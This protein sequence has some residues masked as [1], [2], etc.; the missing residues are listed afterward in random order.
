MT[1]RPARAGARGREHYAAR[2]VRPRPNACLTEV[3]REQGAPTPTSTTCWASSITSRGAWP[4][5]RTMFNEALRINPAYTEAALNLVVTC[6]DLGKYREAKEVYERAMAASKRA[7]RE[8]DPFA[9]GQ[10]RQHARRHRRRL[11]RRRR[12]SR[13]PCAS[14]S[15][16]WRCARRSSTSA[17]SWATTLR[18]MGDMTGR[19]PRVRARAAPRA[20]ASW[21]ARL[22][23]GLGYYAA[24]PARG[25]RRRM[26]AP[27]WR[28]SPATSRAA[29]MYLAHA[30]TRRG[31]AGRA[32]VAEIGRDGG[33]RADLRRRRPTR[34]SSRRSPRTRRRA[35]ASTRSCG[36]RSA[37]SRRSTPSRCWRGALARRCARRRLRGHEGPARDDAPVAERARASTPS[38]RWRCAADGVARARRRRRHG[39][40]LRTGHLRGNRFEVV[41]DRRRDDDEARRC[42]ARLATLGARR[43]C[44]TATASSASAPPATTPPRGL[45]LLRGERRERD[46]RQAQAA[47]VGAAVGGVQP[48]RSSCGPTRRRR[49]AAC[50]AGDVLQKTASGGL[51]V[52]TDAAVDQA[53]VDA[54]ELVTDRAPARRP[55]D[56]AAARHARARARGRG[57]RRASARRARTSR[58]PGRD[59]PGRAPPGPAP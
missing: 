57:A 44:P 54:G 23:L 42:G 59:L 16:R 4:R 25:R 20:R 45:A 31:R 18:E 19:D 48:R 24:G 2:R 7:P 34:S 15:A 55:R 30:A 29:K 13:T 56:R 22:H 41:L 10:D 39:N 35:R 8:L 28:S 5:P 6:N 46:Q 9:Q 1:A 50:C 51:F 40:K 52:S 38:A 27:C 14:T 58:A 33:A 26:A 11:P 49:C 17:P 37:A 3:L 53:R 43:V 36:S 32:V 21:P 12:C 47:A